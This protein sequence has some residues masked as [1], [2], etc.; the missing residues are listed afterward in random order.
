MSKESKSTI[1]EIEEDP[2]D[3]NSCIGG[4][5]LTE[6]NPIEKSKPNVSRISK[7]P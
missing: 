2:S 6:L 7:R 4:F 1:R 5:M 3:G